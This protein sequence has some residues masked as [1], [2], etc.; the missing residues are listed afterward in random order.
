MKQSI[1][2]EFD[3]GC[4]IACFAFATNM[5]YKQAVHYLG[6][7]QANSNRFWVKD[8]VVALNGY[9]KTYKSYHVKPCVR[10]MIYKEWAIVLIHRSKHYPVG[11]YLIRYNSKWMDPWINLPFN[12]DISHAK[13]GFRQRL[14]GSPMFAIIPV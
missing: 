10:Q 9:G 8:I 7:E 5:T 1:T 12:K 6:S 14:P 13:S 4:G 3:Y 11:H 2:Q